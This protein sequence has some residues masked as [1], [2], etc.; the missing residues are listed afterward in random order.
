MIK[1][2]DKV[3]IACMVFAAVAAVFLS[4]NGNEYLLYVG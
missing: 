1:Y 4:I 2:M 3:L